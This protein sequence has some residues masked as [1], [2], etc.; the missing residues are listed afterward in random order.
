MAYWVAFATSGNPNASGLPEWPRYTPDG[1]RILDFTLTGPVA[2][3][4]PWKARLD[5]VEQ[6]AIKGTR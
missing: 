4:D 5:L 3:A 1:D 2:K 6:L